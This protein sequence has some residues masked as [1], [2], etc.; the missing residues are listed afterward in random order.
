MSVRRFA[1]LFAVSLFALFTTCNDAPVAPDGLSP[2]FAAK[3]GT[4]PCGKGPGGGDGTIKVIDL[5]PAGWSFSLPR[6]INRRGQVAGWGGTNF[7]HAFFWDGKQSQDIGTLGG[8]TS[9]MAFILDNYLNDFGMVVGQSTTADGPL[10][11]RLHAFAWTKRQG[12]QDLGTLG[13][14]RS[15]AYAVN[16]TGQVVGEAE[17]ARCSSVVVVDCTPVGAFHAFLWEDGVM[18]DLHT[19]GD[20]WSEAR[21]VNDQ[22]QVS[23]IY[24][25][26]GVRLAFL[27]EDG[28]MQDLGTIGGEVYEVVAINAEGDVTGT[29]KT[30]SGDSHAFLASDGVMEDLGTLGGNR[31]EAWDLNNYGVVVGESENAG[32]LT[33]AFLWQDGAIRDLGTLGGDFSR[34]KGVNDRGEVVGLSTTESGDVHAF[35]WSDGIMRDLG[36][37]GGN[38]SMALAI[39]EKGQVAGE[40]KVASGAVHGALWETR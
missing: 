34:A 30:G 17:T 25:L 27:W 19:L 6:S 9:A 18:Q 37:L 2:S 12:M 26:A 33:H 7:N 28:V 4:P 38:W 13:G 10:G 20:E 3:C 22:G 29:A 16:K 5:N 15:F 24:I 36:T 1:P 11:E 39:N 35:I 21:V 8:G 32:G 40:A 23:G 14:R 31:S